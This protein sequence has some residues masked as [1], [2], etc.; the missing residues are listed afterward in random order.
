MLG[1]F[2]NHVARID[3]TS[4]NVSYEGINEEDARKYV[5]ARGLGVKY[6]LDNGPQVDPLGP[7]NVLV[8]MNGPLVGS[9]ASM[10]G[11]MAAVTKSPLTG[12]VADAHMGGWSGARFRW[13]GFDGL[14]FKGRAAN[15]T[16]A[17][18]EDGKVEL[19]D[20]SDL[21]GKGIHETIAALKERHGDSNV[22]VVAIGQA[23]E[24][25]VR[26]ACMMN[27]DDR[28]WAGAVQDVWREAR[29]LRQLSSRRRR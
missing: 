12:T 8:M 18:C 2:A 17:Y 4:G 25:Q 29:T 20:A 21:W 26:Y 13:A 16:Y 9:A 14:I 15:P 11:R 27:E 19:K 6:V 7:D 28:A 24:N 10:S 3:L 1:G 22:S 5:G 23:G